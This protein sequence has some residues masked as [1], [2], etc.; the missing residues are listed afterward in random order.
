MKT[1]KKETQESVKKLAELCQMDAGIHNK[2]TEADLLNVTV[3]FMHFVMDLNYSKNKLL[4]F[5]KKL[6]EGVEL[7]KNLREFV[8]KFTGKDMKKVAKKFLK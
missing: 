3:V 7:G 2:Y 8:F 4:K 5:E 1:L 6:E